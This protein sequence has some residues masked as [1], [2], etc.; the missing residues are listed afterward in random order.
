MQDEKIE[1]IKK[2]FASV[3]KKKNRENKKITKRKPKGV[4][5]WE[6]VLPERGLNDLKPK[7]ELNTEFFIF[8]IQF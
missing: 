7:K 8:L 1:I 2:N 3:K 4:Y 6:T 5:E